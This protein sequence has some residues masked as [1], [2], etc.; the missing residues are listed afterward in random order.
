M[1]RRGLAADFKS[2]YYVWSG[3][4]QRCT[5]PKLAGY[6][7]YGG[8]GIAVCER[9]LNSFANFLEDMGPRP[10]PQHT[11]ERQ[12]N[13]NDYCKHNC[14]WASRLAQANNKRNNRR[15][16]FN[17]ITLT[18]Q[19][20]SR[21][22]GIDRNTIATRI[23]SGFTVEQAL[24]LGASRHSRLEV[25]EARVTHCPQGHEYTPTNTRYYLNKGQY[26]TR[27]CIACAKTKAKAYHWKNR[28]KIL[29]RKERNR[30]AKKSQALL[31]P[32]TA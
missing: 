12:N 27:Q 17:D 9:W 25:R 11:L 4:I 14:V 20:W 30:Q 18:L 7:N 28:E 23:N 21:I 10:S 8:R 26:L 16:T 32:P 13:H 19:Q 24:T 15:I 22:T 2:E 6:K 29:A 3:M 5:N 1:P 31:N